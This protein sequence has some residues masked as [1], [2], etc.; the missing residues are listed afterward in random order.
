MKA[1]IVNPVDAYCLPSVP[2]DSP[3]ATYEDA[4]GSL[5]NLVN[6]MFDNTA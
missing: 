6:I 4:D 2:R 1:Y 3:A 5:S